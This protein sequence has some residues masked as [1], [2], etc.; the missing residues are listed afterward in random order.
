MPPNRAKF[1]DRGCDD[2]PMVDNA[3]RIAGAV[4]VPVVS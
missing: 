3:R 4:A 2:R 1:V